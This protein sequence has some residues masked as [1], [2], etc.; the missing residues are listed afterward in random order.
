MVKDWSFLELNV[1][2]ISLGPYCIDHKSVFSI[3][4]TLGFSYICR[5][6]KGYLAS[7]LGDKYPSSVKN[8][9]GKKPWL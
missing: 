9:F 1:I 5:N 4:P 8:T 6:V 7:L 3:N 2:T